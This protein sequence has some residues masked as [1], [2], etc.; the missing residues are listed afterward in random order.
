[1]PQKSV[2]KN[3]RRGTTSEQNSPRQE[4]LCSA[5]G[6]LRVGQH[7][8]VRRP[9]GLR[10]NHGTAEEALEPEGRGKKK[11]DTLIGRTKAEEA[12]RKRRDTVI[13]QLRAVEAERKQRDMVIGQLKAAEARNRIRQM[14]LRYQSIRAKE[15]SLMV[16]CQATA[17]NAIRLQ[18]LLPVKEKKCVVRDTLDRLQRR[19]V[20]E[21][22]DDD[23]EPFLTRR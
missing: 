12:G 6:E 16:S 15:I 5:R 4:C 20:E 13:G 14:R 11:R 1:M 10:E 2:R 19:R 7:S 3:G 23:G 9:T 21:L 22:L 17:Q 8:R 18:Q